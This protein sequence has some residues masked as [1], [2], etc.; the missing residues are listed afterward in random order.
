MESGGDLL[1][2]IGGRVAP[3]Q[4]VV[5]RVDTHNRSLEPVSDTGSHALFVTFNR[6]ISVDTSIMQ[7][8]EPDSFYYSD[9][10]YIRRY[11]E[12]SGAWSEEATLKDGYGR[13]DL[14]YN[15]YYPKKFG[16]HRL[17]KILAGFCRRGEFYELLMGN[18]EGDH[19]EVYRSK[20]QGR[21]NETCIMYSHV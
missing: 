2:V 17:D 6:C 18:D 16:P 1:L 5:Y 12:E 13:N 7:T 3:G 4:P 10:S 15:P 14:Y 20:M 8:V 19:E 9:F 21:V 11:C